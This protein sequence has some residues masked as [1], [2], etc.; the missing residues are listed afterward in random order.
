MKRLNTLFAGAAMA[1]LTA[2]AAFAE[3]P[4]RP[5]NMVIPFG[6]GGGDGHFRALAFQAFERCRG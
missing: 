4:E 6:A 2:T 1:A 5:V 3:Y